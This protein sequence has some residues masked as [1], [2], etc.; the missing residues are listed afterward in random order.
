M[1][2]LPNQAPVRR[3]TKKPIRNNPRKAMGPRPEV[4]LLAV[5]GMSP[6]I[7][8]ETIW[9]LAQENPPVLPDRLT[10]LTTSAGKERII[11][12]L[13][14]EQSHFN[15]QRG[16]GC[17]LQKL[18]EHGHDAKCRLRFDP[19]SEDVRVLARW[20]ERSRRKLSL[21]DIRTREENEVVADSILEVVRGIVANPDTRLIASI[22]GGRKTMGTLLYACMT[23]IG[24][25]TDRVTH[26]LV[27]E[28]FDDP[29]LKPKFYFPQQPA[30][31]LEVPPENK[32]VQAKDA[33]IVLADLPFVPVRNL[34]AKELGRMPGGFT[35]LVTQCSNEVRHRAAGDVK[36]VV[37][38][39]R[40]EIE[41][42]GIPIELSARE[43]L[44][45]LFLAYQAHKGHPPFGSYKEGTDSLNEFR[46]QLKAGAPAN[47]FSDWRWGSG[48]GAAFDSREIV[49]VL[50]DLRKKLKQA[51]SDAN[52]LIDRL[53]KHGRLSLD[54]QKA[55]IRIVE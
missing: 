8:T 41:V 38:R 16:W 30:T 23:L 20:E 54:L 17:L 45:V 46:E 42:N 4:V 43:Q 15:H 5:T 27:D 9:A 31:E 21:N 49:R 24:R 7:L 18:E 10:V 47:D 34:F 2:C 13:F 25:E 36:L 32:V 6:A 29:R 40:P 35:A 28:P 48:Q 1:P 44:L 37:H 14:T 51:S 11:Q 33:R 50:S 53:P 3:G 19:D 52:L 26:V 39:L 22:A 55:Q 12:E